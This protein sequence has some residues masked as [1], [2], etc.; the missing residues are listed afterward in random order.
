MIMPADP[1]VGDVYR[2]ENIPGLVFEEVTVKETA[3][4]FRGR[5][6]RSRARWS[7]ASCTTTARARTR[8][9]RPATAS[10][11]PRTAAISRRWRW[12]SRPTRSHPDA[13]RADGA[14]PRRA[15]QAPLVRSDARDVARR[16]PRRAAAPCAPMTRA[17]RSR[18][19][20]HR[21]RGARSAAPVPAAGRDRPRAVRAVDAPRAARRRAP[22][23]RRAPRR[24]RHADV[25]PRPD[26]AQHR[27]RRP[28]APR[29]PARDLEA[30]S[31][32][33]TSAPRAD[34][35]LRARRNI[36][37]AGGV[38]VSRCSP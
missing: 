15:R 17:L 27:Q 6:D 1:R 18:P 3:A 32:T 5:A 13:G 7:R 14:P 21:G 9:S 38:V 35:A 19:V 2:P 8:S 33:A 31:P 16:P 37:P 28:R 30:A 36:A 20:R 22:P 4:P 24:R 29:P 34:A 10:S 26:R 23:A 25:D 11:G 12:P